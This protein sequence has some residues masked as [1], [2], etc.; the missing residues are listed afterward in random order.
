MD[1]ERVIRSRKRFFRRSIDFQSAGPAGFQPAEST[2]RDARF[3]HRQDACATGSHY[4][5]FEI[6][7]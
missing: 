4:P 1:H 7:R 3:P 2:G 6:V 5:R